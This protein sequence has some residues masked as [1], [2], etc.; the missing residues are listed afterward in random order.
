GPQGP[1]GSVQGMAFVKF[2]CAANS[3]PLIQGNNLLC[4]NTISQQSP[5]AN[6]AIQQSALVQDGIELLKVGIYEITTTAAIIAGL[7]GT[8]YMDILADNIPVSRVQAYYSNQVWKSLHQ[9]TYIYVTT[10]GTI[11]TSMIT[12]N[13][14]TGT[15]WHLSENTSLQV[16]Y[17][18]AGN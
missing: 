15:V 7:G 2:K 14:S 12:M 9:S 11:V 1:A 3:S 18:G 4:L 8:A 17:L 10:P 6:T 13:A 16:M 5:L